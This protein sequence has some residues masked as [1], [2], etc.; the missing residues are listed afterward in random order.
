MPS[1]KIADSVRLALHALDVP[2]D[3]L[4]AELQQRHGLYGYADALR[5]IHRP[6]DLADKDRA[7]RRLKWDEA[8]TLQVLL[9][10]RRR[11]AASYS[12]MPAAAG[13]R[14]ACWPS[15][16]PGCRSS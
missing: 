3:P 14:A 9:A 12:A 5:G 16:T 15:S 1:W 6:V 2:D 11:A 10:Q 4:P 8:F 7:G 13:R